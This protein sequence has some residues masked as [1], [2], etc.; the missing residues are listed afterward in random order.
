LPRREPGVELEL[1]LLLTLRR[2]PGQAVGAAE[3][4]G[5]A[6]GAA[7]EV[8]ERR[9]GAMTGGDDK[10]GVAGVAA[11]AADA[12]VAAAVV[13]IAPAGNSAVPCPHC[14]RRAFKYLRSLEK[15]VWNDHGVGLSRDELDSFEQQLRAG[16][17]SGG[18]A[19][20]STAA[21]ATPAGAG[22]GAGAGGGGGQ[23]TT[24]SAVGFKRKVGM[25]TLHPVA[26]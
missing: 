11:V 23:Q 21:F 19:A 18:G 15:H 20:G 16:A 12:A 5:A 17:A 3:A 14:D 26:L 4:A 22:A 1:G 6:G 9:G 2:P 13:P 24:L 8:E 10:A 25:Y 7:M